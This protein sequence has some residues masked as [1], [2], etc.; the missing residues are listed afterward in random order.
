MGFGGVGLRCTATGTLHD[1]V[2]SKK[3]RIS[4]TVADDRD[5]CVARSTG[6]GWLLCSPGSR[7]ISQ[8]N[9]TQET[10]WLPPADPR[11]RNSAGRRGRTQHHNTHTGWP[12]GYTQCHFFAGIGGWSVALAL[13][14]WPGNRAGLDRLM[15]CSVAFARGTPESPCRRTTPVARFSRAHRSPQTIRHLW[16]AGCERRWIRNGSPEFVLTGRKW[17]CRQG[18]RS[19]RC[20]RR[21]AANPGTDLLG[22]LRRTGLD[23]RAHGLLGACGV[24]EGHRSDR[25][26]PRVFGD[27]RWTPGRDGRGDVCPRL[28]AAIMGFPPSF[29][30]SA[31]RSFQRSPQKIRPSVPRVTEPANK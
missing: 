28:C 4:R 13:A 21:L 30:D 26:F 16:R 8:T 20:G 22:C 23:G 1:P 10:A 25:G 29:V 19:V 11:R 6:P 27:G 31:M 12:R 15:S 18:L 9:T 7:R 17:I 14:G 24:R 2:R 3:I 5:A